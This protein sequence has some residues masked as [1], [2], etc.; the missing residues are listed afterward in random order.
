MKKFTLIEL[1][2]VVAIIGIL[3]SILIPSL[4]NAKKAANIAVCMSNM[5][6]LGIATQSYIKQNNGFYPI[7]YNHSRT[8]TGPKISW[9]DKLS[10][11]DGREL[12]EKQILNQGGT[13]QQSPLYECA[14]TP[15]RGQNNVFRSYSMSA[16][17]K[18]VSKN[19]SNN[20]KLLGVANMDGN[21]SMHLAKI[22]RPAEGI[23]LFEY[24]VSGN[25]LGRKYNSLRNVDRVNGYTNPEA[26]FWTHKFGSMNFLF[27]DSSVRYMSLMSTFKGLRSPWDSAD[28]YGT[29]WDCRFD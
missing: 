6:Q 26:D 25:T 1:L 4:S 5:K 22:P 3:V 16:G 15:F 28:Q 14:A 8:Y 20:R 10:P 23:V 18:S 9:D 12:T 7:D 29:M 21:W 17:K 13:L 24:N 11:Y 27:S 2:V 19:N